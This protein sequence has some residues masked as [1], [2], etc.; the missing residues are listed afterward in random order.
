MSVSVPS[1]NRNPKIWGPKY[2][3]FLHS[4]ADC[5][6]SFPNEIT[7]KKY[8]ELIQNF[9]LFIPHSYLSN[10]F[11]IFLDKYPI[12][13]YL[14]NRESF[15]KWVFFIHNKMNIKTGRQTISVEQADEDFED[16][17]KSLQIKKVNTEYKYKTYA[18]ICI[19]CVCLIIALKYFKQ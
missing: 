19:T 11:S 6:P 15:K 14:D 17:Y 2:W 13:P 3:F 16:Y 12:T 8:Y 10:E 4:I 5:Y 1:E 9:P 18:Y 7:K